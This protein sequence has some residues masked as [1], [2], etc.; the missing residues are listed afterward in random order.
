MSCPRVNWNT[1]YPKWGSG[2]LKNSK[3]N[4]KNEYKIRNIDEIK[5]GFSK[6][7][8][9]LKKFNIKNKINPSKIAS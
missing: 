3:M 4:L 2:A 8:F 5:P 7:F 6:K 9:F 1:K